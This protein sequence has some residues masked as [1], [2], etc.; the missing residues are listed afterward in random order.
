MIDEQK[1]R[2]QYRDHEKGFEK[3]KVE[4]SESLEKEAGAFYQSTRFKVRV[5]PPRIKTVDSLISKMKNKGILISSL[6]SKSDE[7][8][9][10]AVND[11]IGARI[12]CNTRED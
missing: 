5:L 6:F 3:I 12:S 2:E 7:E 4:L 1:I 11:F 9:S 8:L 10:L